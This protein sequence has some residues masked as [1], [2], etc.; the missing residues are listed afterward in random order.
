MRLAYRS[1]WVAPISI[2]A[3]SACIAIAPTGIHRQ[4]DTPDAGDDADTFD[5][6]ARPP[7]N[8]P[9]DAS[10]NDP[11]AVIGAEPAHGPFL[12][13][14]RVLLHGKGFSSKA[15]VWFG[16][17]EAEPA[18]IIAVDPSR[19]QVTAPPGK[20]GL[21]D[22]SVQNGD[23]TS[24]RRT[25]AGGYTYDALYAMPDNGPVPGGTV[26]EIIGQ[27]TAWDSTSVARI[28]NKPCTTLTVDGPTKLVCTVPPGTPGAKTITVT[29]GAEKILV[30][31]AY[32]YAD[33]TDGYKGG[34][35]GLPLSGNLKVLV[36]DN[37]TGEPIPEA[38]V[39]VGSDITTA[40]VAHAD[41]TGVAVIAD[42][43]LT[44]PRTVTVAGV[45]H[46]PITFVSE[47][48]DTV[49]A[50]LDPTLTPECASGGDPP[51]VGGK[52]S[53]LGTIQ[54]ELVWPTIDEF[55][56]GGWQN[57]PQPKTENEHRA[58]YV[59]VASGDPSQ[60]FYLPAPSSAVTE[61]SDGERG[62]RFTLSALPGNR[63]I[64]AVAGL[65]D[66]TVSPPKFT[67]YAMGA[68]NGVPVLPNVVTTD[69]YIDMNRTLDLALS[70]DLDPPAPGPKGPDRL[71]ATVAVRLGPD[72]YAILPG[73]Q[74]SPFLPV[75]G[76]LTFV[77]LPLLDGALAGSVYVSSARAVTG[78]AGGAPLS[79][80]G[81]MLSTTTSE[82]LPV[83]GF[84]GVPL[85]TTPAP[86][87]AWD[88]K[89]IT[90]S[91]APGG[92]PIELTVLDISSGNGLVHWLIAAPGGAQAITVP[93]LSGFPD[94]AL[95]P[96][97]L[98]IAVYGGHLDPFDYTKLRYRDLRPTGMLAYSLDYFDAH[99]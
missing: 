75:Q 90:V 10:S 6:D 51:P 35:S 32:T 46:S 78:Q 99:H 11:H 54:G 57:V 45:C 82:P 77:G 89:N 23:D 97:P 79:V 61:L 28:D 53:S 24:T 93:D 95:P 38:L 83:T 52:P 19:V 7:D 60:P 58:A 66:L 21:T 22:L 71:K 94:L 33:S 96:G 36:Y 44:G 63:S 25:L 81:R 40:I 87:T 37:Y 62:Y 64:Y 2:L 30:L 18:G 31:D 73:A 5:F 56:K 55:K 15:R 41:E 50:Y 29:T 98:K 43:S 17:V 13:G 65:E 20:A 49:T 76:L 92:S 86:N 39:V 9:P 59:L 74:K 16:D 14:Q 80:I 85:L 4:T 42:P 67:A 34:L 12:G 91:F 72:G 1:L 8:P 48:V 68:I 47:P 69:V 3:L 26:I 88:G 27:A 70:M 84:V